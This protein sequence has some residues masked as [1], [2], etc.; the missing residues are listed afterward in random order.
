L[1]ASRAQVKA[2]NAS[3]ALVLSLVCAEEIIMHTLLHLHPLLHLLH[4]L[5]SKFTTTMAVAQDQTTMA[6]MKRRKRR[7]TRKSLMARALT[8][9]NT[10]HLFPYIN[11]F[12]NLH[13]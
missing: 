12:K 1:L 7:R 9:T 13:I 6:L 3:A 8:E 11:S 5:S 2:V 4:P 10:L